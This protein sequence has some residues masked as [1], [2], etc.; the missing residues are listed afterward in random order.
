MTLLGKQDWRKKCINSISVFFI[1]LL[2]CLCTG[3]GVQES[4]LNEG[5]DFF[6]RLPV[7][8]SSQ[9]VEKFCGETIRHKGWYDAPFENPNVVDSGGGVLWAKRWHFF[10]LSNERY[11]VGLS[12]INFGYISSSLPSKITFSDLS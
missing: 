2:C 6:Q 4:P 3:C 9:I 10:Y 1:T 11:H 7:P 8:E 5:V 12:I